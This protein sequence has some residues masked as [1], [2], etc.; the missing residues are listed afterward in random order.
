MYQNSVSPSL[1]TTCISITKTVIV[2]L[3][4]EN[5]SRDIVDSIET[6]VWAGRF[7]VRIAAAQRDLSVSQNAQPESGAQAASYS[8]CNGGSLLGGKVTGGSG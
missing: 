6:G 7:R 2:A 5:R 4:W 3:Y 1:K 8:V